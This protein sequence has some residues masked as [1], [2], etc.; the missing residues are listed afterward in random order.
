[1]GRCVFEALLDYPD[2]TLVT[3]VDFGTRVGFCPTNASESTIDLTIVYPALS[4]CVSI[5]K[6]P[7]SG[8]DHL[9]I[10]STFNA[11]PTKGSVKVPRWLF[12][13][14]KRGRLESR[15]GI[16]AARQIVPAVN[17]HLS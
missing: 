17:G 4:V 7:Y 10:I 12:D 8:S 11:T 13:D 15:F 6:G 2:A 5:V 1:M 14:K 16:F 3:P 9:P